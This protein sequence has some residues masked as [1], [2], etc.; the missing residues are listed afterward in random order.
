MLRA[1]AAQRIE[2]FQSGRESTALLQSP[3]EQN[4]SLD[5]RRSR[6]QKIASRPLR[7]CGFTTAQ[8]LFDAIERG[9]IRICNTRP[10]HGEASHRGRHARPKIC[11]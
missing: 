11:S 10:V 6:L 1:Q 8:Q 4:H 5:A 7:Q 3:A 2:T 9:S